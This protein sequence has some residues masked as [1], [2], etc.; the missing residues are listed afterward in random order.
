[1]ID[2]PSQY[3]GVET[4]CC[5]SNSHA[6][7]ITR[8]NKSNGIDWVQNRNEYSSRLVTS[9]TLLATKYSHEYE[10]HCLIYIFTTPGTYIC[11]IADIYTS[12]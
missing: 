11:S 5:R 2:L 12:N 8:A 7:P 6:V 9:S 10:F 1:M 4:C 3:R